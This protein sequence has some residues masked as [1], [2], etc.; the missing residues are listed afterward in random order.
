MSYW[1][2]GADDSDFAF[3]A[4]GA[5]IYLLKERMLNDIK[6]VREKTC[7]EQS[8]VASLVCL[9]LIGERFPKSLSVHFR[10][11]DFESARR[12]FEDWYEAVRHKLPPEYRARIAEEAR[13][14]FELFEERILGRPKREAG[15]GEPA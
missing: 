3:G 2:S 4:V 6:V 8:I 13:V 11:A 5:Y 15:G 10:R 7:P 1:G 9:R 14:E 12:A